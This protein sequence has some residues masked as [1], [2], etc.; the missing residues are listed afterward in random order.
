MGGQILGGGAIALVVALLWL[1]YLL[2]SWHAKVRYNAAERNAVV[3]N[4]ALRVLAETSET[5][6]EV[7]I[8]LSRREAAKQQRL[9]KR[10]QAEDD[11]LRDRT[12]KLAL[13]QKKREVE[14][15]RLSRI[16]AAE[17]ER[18]RLAAL[19]ADPRIGQA[20]A[21]RR[22]R[23]VATTLA[24]VG[25]VVAG[26]GAWQFAATGQ[27]TWIAVGAASFVAGA[28]VI[29][30]MA[31]VA[32]RV[33]SASRAPVAVEPARAE[34]RYEPQLL[35]PEDR[36]WTPRR[37]PAP[38]TATAGSSAAD[39]VGAA[40]AQEL[41]RQAALEAAGRERLEAQRPAPVSIER[42]RERFAQMGRV[43]D[44][45]IEQHV[46]ELLARRAAG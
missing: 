33:R 38:L 8:E 9:V 44:A 1:V 16:A 36:G 31:S 34:R 25:L 11:R 42:E 43:D 10:M 20:R 13:A 12:D 37:L 32:S 27:W 3:L 17:D 5:P 46:R 35:N 28:V 14:A 39:A 40:S 22:L 19:R 45:E 23:L 2:P 7:R 26:L 18:A 24:A 6:E 4:Q 41:L 29:R 21:R 30:R 15:E